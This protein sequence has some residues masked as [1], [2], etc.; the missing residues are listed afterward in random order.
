MVKALLG[1]GLLLALAVPALAAPAGRIVTAEGQVRVN[2]KPASEGAVVSAGDRLTVGSQSRAVV[3]LASGAAFR[4]GPQTD[5]RIEALGKQT[6]LAL[7]KGD[8]LTA[9]RS[10]SDFRVR[11]PK[12]VA[13]VR[14]TTFYMQ[15]T[16]VHPSLICI[17]HG[18]VDVSAPGR[19]GRLV[20]TDQH[21]VY[22]V[23]PASRWIP[24]EVSG[25]TDEE[26]A[27]LKVLAEA[28]A[29]E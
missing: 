24:L 18:K 6:R 7:K 12:V 25:H 11:A 17:C 2:G 28:P 27:A 10:G 23:K 19:P 9:V 21:K 29:E 1:M 5:L 8:I 20:D 3:T 15:A 16:P 13:A 14:G 22:A 26:A 4:L